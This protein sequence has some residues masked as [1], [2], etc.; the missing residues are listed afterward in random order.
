MSIMTNKSKTEIIIGKLVYCNEDILGQGGFGFV[1]KGK[2]I[3]Y[4]GD[5][6]V[7]VAIKRLQ[8]ANLSRTFKERELK[9]KELDHQN[10]VKLFHVEENDDFV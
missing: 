1:F 4:K 10:V 7:D 3:H 2:L 8:K 5:N 9:Q 6:E